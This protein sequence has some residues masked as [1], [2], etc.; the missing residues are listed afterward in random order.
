[1]RFRTWNG[2]SKEPQ[3]IPNGIRTDPERTPNGSR[4]DPERTPNDPK[5]E[6]YSI[7]RLL[8][9]DIKCLN[10]LAATVAVAAVAMSAAAT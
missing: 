8:R 10:Q 9:I 2:I 3:R 5:I 1:M 4:M 7:R 6:I